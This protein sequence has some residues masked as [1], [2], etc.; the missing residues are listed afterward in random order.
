MKFKIKTKKKKPKKKKVKINYEYLPQPRKRVPVNLVEKMFKLY[1]QEYPQRAIAK[2]CGVTQ[3]TVF[4]Y[5][6]HGDPDR[7]IEPLKDRRAR[8]MQAMFQH[9]D[10]ELVK[11]QA[12]HMKLAS[13]GFGQTTARLLKRYRAAEALDEYEKLSLEE[14]A[15]YE[16]IAQEPDLDDMSAFH[17]ASM[18]LMRLGVRATS[19]VNINVTQNQGQQQETTSNTASDG[20][21]DVIFEH[22]Y[23]LAG[24]DAKSEKQIADKVKER[25]LSVERTKEDVGE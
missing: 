17:R 25:S 24:A 7:H 11:R 9:N 6:H 22:I 12:Q 20:S 14:R 18:D 13:A 5:I 10:E 8:V 1:C 15:I 21:V 3:D 16:R 19:P 4:R 2:E 23:A